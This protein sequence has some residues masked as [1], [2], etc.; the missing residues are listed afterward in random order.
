MSQDEGGITVFDATEAKPF[1]PAN[2]PTQN[3]LATKPGDVF[4]DRLDVRGKAYYEELLR[5][6]RAARVAAEKRV[7]ELESIIRKMQGGFCD[8][9]GSH[10]EGSEDID[11]T[12]PMCAILIEAE[13]IAAKCRT[14]KALR[15]G[16]KEEPNG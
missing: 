6:E 1:S 13:E 8:E 14:D 11:D 3:P 12:C 10:E 16:G 2:G 15:D 5:Q 9:H 4:P 7:A